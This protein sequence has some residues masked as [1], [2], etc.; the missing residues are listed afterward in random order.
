[1]SDLFVASQAKARERV[2]DSVG[3]VNVQGIL[4]YVSCALKVGG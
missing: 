4:R 1:M 3:Q 2:E